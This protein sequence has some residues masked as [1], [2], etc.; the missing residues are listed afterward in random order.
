MYVCISEADINT[1]AF[2]VKHITFYRYLC[3]H[4]YNLCISDMYNIITLCAHNIEL[5]GRG[6]EKT[7]IEILTI[8]KLNLCVWQ[9]II[10][11]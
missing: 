5:W 2:Y 11:T 8:I 3:V 7:Y 10:L 4:T 9:K 1:Y 6:R